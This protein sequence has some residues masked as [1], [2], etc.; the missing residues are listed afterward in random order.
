LVDRGSA[1]ALWQVTDERLGK[2]REPA[3]HTGGQRRRAR[4]QLD[5]LDAQAL[6]LQQR[7][8]FLRS[9]VVPRLRRG[10][11][12]AASV[13]NGNEGGDHGGNVAKSTELAYET[14][15]RPQRTV[16]SRDDL[17]RACHPMQGR[18]GKHC[19]ELG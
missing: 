13:E 5:L 3:R 10:T 2:S 19:V 16:H 7:R 14:S 6:R 17:H 9:R 15:T 12:L 4:D 8:V 18:I 11:V 1:L